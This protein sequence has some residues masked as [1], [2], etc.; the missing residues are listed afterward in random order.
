MPTEVR[1]MEQVGSF[2]EIVVWSH[3]AVPE[4]ED[5][6]V[7]G[8]EEWIGFAESVSALRH[9]E[10]RGQRADVHGTDT[11]LRRANDDMR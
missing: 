1:V 6:Y 9:G 11:R 3:E 4:S 8:I 2:E 5:V 10:S 7:K